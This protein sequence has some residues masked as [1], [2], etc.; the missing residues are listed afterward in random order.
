MTS[1]AEP[2]K[3]AHFF[4]NY[5]RLVGFTYVAIVLSTLGLFLFQIQQKHAEEV[6]VIQGHVDR[7]AQFVE[8]ILRSSLD[9][10]EAL[11]LSADNFYDTAPLALSQSE[12]HL[13]HTPLFKSLKQQDAQGFNLNQ[14]REKDSTGNLIGLGRLSGRKP[15]FYLDVEMALNLN[16]LFQAVAF[17]L[18]NANE[19]RFIS[20]ENFS[21]TY[22]WMEAAKR[23]HTEQTYQSPAWLMGT[24]EKNPTREKYW[25]PVYYGGPAVGLLVPTAVPIYNKGQFRGVVS[26]DTSVDYLNR[27]N[28]DFAYKPGTAFLVDAYGQV[29]AHPDVYANALEVQSTQP[30]DKVMPAGVLSAGRG[31]LDIPPNQPTH[32]G[33]YLVIRHPFISA[34]WQ[35]VFVV[36]KNQLWK[37]L[38]LERG[39]LMLL[40]LLGLTLLMVVT[41]YVTSREFISPAAK[42]VAHIAAESQFTPAP[43]P[44]VPSSWKPWFET[45]SEAFRKSLKL[46]SVQQELNIA[47]DMQ[48]SMLPRQ[49][50]RQKEF[51]LWGLMRSA[52]EVGGDF[53]DH[54]PLPGG[55]IGIVVADVSGKGVPA[56]LF[57]MVSKT[58]IR[59]TATSASGD[60]GETIAIANDFV[61]ED[62]DGSSFVTTFYAV[63]DPSAGSFT[64]VN[65]GHPPPLLVHSDDGTTEFLAMTDGIALGV[66]DGMVFAQQTLQLRPGDYVIMYTDGVTEAFNPQGEEFTEQRLPPLFRNCPVSD[67]NAAALRILAAVDDHANGAPQ[68]DDITCVVLQ[69]HGPAA[70]SAPTESAAEAA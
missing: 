42:L 30:L 64:Y 18:P 4:R 49:W 45:I 10:L 46:A 60:A 40:V 31:L 38:L 26:I 47:A 1:P 50:P 59:A 39:P 14:V 23:P 57:G 34:P 55:K 13:A 41:Y 29:V 35:L 12:R 69:F 65:G 62:N 58:V 61:S 25:A 32:A 28:S 70:T 17:N 8:F 56:A 48:L 9:N 51:S 5:N 53:Y 43:M 33:D 21:H 63:F 54:F 44:A 52:K 2:A 68:S 22:P 20:V 16:Q 24:P 36:P 6:K 15:E 19:S 11:R 27:I 3:S 67:V 66:T 7:H 37:N